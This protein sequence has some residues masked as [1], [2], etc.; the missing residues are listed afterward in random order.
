MGSRNY[1]EFL[2]RENGKDDADKEIAAAEGRAG[3]AAAI[4]L[5]ALHCPEAIRKFGQLHNI[6][7]FAEM[8]WE[9]GFIAGMRA[10]EL[11][12]NRDIVS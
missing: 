11:L 4:I 3:V 1:S 8:T 9:A 12:R 6:P 5:A 10:V 7:L 2:A